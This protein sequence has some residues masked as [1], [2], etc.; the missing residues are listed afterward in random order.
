MK[1]GRAVADCEG[2]QRSHVQRTPRRFKICACYCSPRGPVPVGQLGPTVSPG[3]GPVCPAPTRLCRGGT[4][5]LEVMV[6]RP[7]QRHSA[8]HIRQQLRGTLREVALR[9]C[10]FSSRAWPVLHGAGSRSCKQRLS[11]TLLRTASSVLATAE[12]GRKPSGC[13]SACQT[14]QKTPPASPVAFP[15]SSVPPR[16]PQRPRR[17]RRRA[18]PRAFARAAPSAERAWPLGFSL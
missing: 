1:S 15:A 8:S 12:T 9:S 10:G 11:Y 17:P 13:G 3:A 16:P 6:S 4:W 7:S 2:P 5:N 18:G 14:L